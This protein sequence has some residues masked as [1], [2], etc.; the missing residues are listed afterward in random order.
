MAW[1]APTLDLGGFIAIAER[2]IKRL[3]SRPEGD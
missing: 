3:D 1:N 2:I